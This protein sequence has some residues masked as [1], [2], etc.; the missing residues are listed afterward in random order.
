MLG[1]A[2]LG[3]LAAVDA[4]LVR[5]QHDA[6]GPPGIRSILPASVG[7]QKLWITSSERSD[8][9]TGTAGRYVQ[10]IGVGQHDAAVGIGDSAPPTTTGAR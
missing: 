3:A 9:A 10:F 2:E 4:R 1:A 7:T 6:V 8:T 5:L